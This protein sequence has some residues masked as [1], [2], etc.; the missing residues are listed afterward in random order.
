MLRP[1]T[2]LAAFHWFATLEAVTEFGRVLRPGGH[3]VLIWNRKD[4][5][6]KSVQWARDI[7]ELLTKYQDDAPRYRCVVQSTGETTQIGLA[8]S[9]YRRLYIQLRVYNR[10]SL[11]SPHHLSIGTA[12][13]AMR[14]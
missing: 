11:H 8:T 9:N 1:L 6:P 3:L 10:H 5:G 4:E 2:R 7:E 12:S 14:S 13:G